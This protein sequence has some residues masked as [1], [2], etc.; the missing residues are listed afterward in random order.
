MTTYFSKDHEWIAVEGDTATIGIT[1]YAQE[2]L[3]DVVFVELPETGKELSQG[4]EAAVVESVKAASELYAPIDG[5]VTEA[6]EVLA[7]EP[8]KVNEDPEGAAWFIKMKV[9]NESQLSELMDEAAYK[10]YVETL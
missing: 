5:E 3:G 9:S 6:N 2:Q 10:A 7:D 8:A 4:D 1:G